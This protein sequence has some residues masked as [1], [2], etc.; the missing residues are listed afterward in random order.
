M[1][2]SVGITI[3][4]RIL[5]DDENSQ[6]STVER[7]HTV[8]RV[9]MAA[10]L[11]ILSADLRN[12][13]KKFEA[14]V[15]ALARQLPASPGLTTYAHKQQSA[16]LE[17]PHNNKKDKNSSYEEPETPPDGFFGPNFTLLLS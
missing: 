1:R 13:V 11:T 17:I 16:S 7:K 9:V 4:G 5:L 6:T 15:L 12:Q 10:D 3:A 8:R 2:E 14:K